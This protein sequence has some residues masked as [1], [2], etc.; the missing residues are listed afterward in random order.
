MPVSDRTA[1]TPIVTARVDLDDQQDPALRDPV[2]QG[3]A[4][5][6]GEQ[7]ADGRGTGASERSAAPPPIA[8]IC[9]TSATIQTPEPTRDETSAAAS[10]RYAG[11]LRG[12]SA[13]GICMTFSLS[14]CRVLLLM[15]RSNRTQ[16]D[17]PVENPFLI[18][19]GSSGRA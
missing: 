1:T 17:R 3:A 12:R 9:Q 13:L 16:I 15:S 7:H 5:Q 8:T 11:V 19:Y 18:G 10:Q 4:E 2:G 6:R 14:K